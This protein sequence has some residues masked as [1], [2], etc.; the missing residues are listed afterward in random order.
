MS[1]VIKLKQ[2]DIENIVEDIVNKQ[3]EKNKEVS[4]MDD[5]SGTDVLIGKDPKTGKIVVFNKNTGDILG[6]K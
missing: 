4:E 2:S 1:K 6:Q 5:T 3:L